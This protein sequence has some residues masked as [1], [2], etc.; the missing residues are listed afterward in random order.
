MSFY[1]LNPMSAIL[2]KFSGG[3]HGIT[4]FPKLHVW[5]DRLAKIFML[6]CGKL[7]TVNML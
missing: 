6:S 7:S 4:V 5:K 1:K 2:G 3:Y